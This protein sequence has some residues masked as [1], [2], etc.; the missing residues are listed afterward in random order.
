MKIAIVHDWLTNMGGAERV[1]IN[2]HELYPSAPIY[3]TF[4]TPNNLDEELRNIDVRVS[5]LQGKKEVV[6]HKKYFPLMPFAFRKFNLKEY[7]VILSSSSSCAKG[8]KK[9]KDN[10]HICYIHTPMRYAYE[11]KHE[12]TDGMNPIKKFLV[13]ILLFFMRIWDKHNS[14]NVDYFIANSHEVQKRV[15][16]TYNRESVVINPPVRCSLFDLSDTDGDYYFVVSRLVPYKKFDLAVQA[17]KELGKKLII[18]GD[19]PEREKLEKIADGDKN[20]VFMGRQPDDV[21]KKY[22]QECKALLFPGLEDFGIV[23]VEA[24]ACGRPVIGYGKG[25]ILDTVI[26]GKTGVLFKEQTVESLK[27]AIQ[28]FET[29]NFDKQKIRDH[30]LKFDES[31]F[32]RKIKDFIDEKIEE[33]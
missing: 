1:I 26:D 24:Q 27:E 19:G 22:M 14:K 5:F 18:I 9:K 6:N 8:A 20:I 30:S 25:G 28:K 13:N 33:K 17:C 21:L 11:F 15:K 31:E 2:F 3:T 4:Y 10:L 29:M 23:P 16:K 32:K 12:Y 7:D